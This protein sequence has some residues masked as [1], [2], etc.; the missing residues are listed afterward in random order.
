M[1]ATGAPRLFGLPKMVAAVQ[2]GTGIAAADVDGDGIV[3]LALA[4]AGNLR[5]LKAELEAP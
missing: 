3:D 4:S 5:V 1:T 2:S